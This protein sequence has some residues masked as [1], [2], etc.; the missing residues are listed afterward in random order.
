MVNRYRGVITFVAGAD[1]FVDYLFMD[2]SIEMEEAA[3]EKTAE[4]I[5]V[6]SICLI[7]KIV[8][9]DGDKTD[10]FRMLFDQGKK[11]VEIQLCDDFIAVQ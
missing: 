10:R 4:A 1:S 3:M 9:V 11:L 2:R 5:P 6:N 7:G 8:V